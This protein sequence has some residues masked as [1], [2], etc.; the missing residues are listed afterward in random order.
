MYGY[1]IRPSLD[2]RVEKQRNRKKHR[3]L[4]GRFTSVKQRIAKHRKTAAIVVWM[5]HR[6]IKGKVPRSYAL[7][8]KKEVGVD[9]QIPMEL[10]S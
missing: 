7:E 10:E 9:V 6:K 2:H 1:R 5:K 4:T 3:N 8:S